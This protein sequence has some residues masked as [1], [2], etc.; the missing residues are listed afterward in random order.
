MSALRLREFLE[1]FG[2]LPFEE[3]EYITEILN[4]QMADEN[5]KNIIKRLKDSRVNNKNG[6]VKEGTV[7]DLYEDLENDLINPRQRIQK[8]L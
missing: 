1:S 7:K 4:K 5:R 8:K 6:A 3:K 2:N